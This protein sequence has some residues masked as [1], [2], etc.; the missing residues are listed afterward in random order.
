MMI[1]TI[2]VKV[3]D[4]K[5]ADYQVVAVNGVV[6]ILS[7]IINGEDVWIIKTT[8]PAALIAALY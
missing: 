4:C 5:I 7:D 8:S 6:S 1:K 3:E 2:I